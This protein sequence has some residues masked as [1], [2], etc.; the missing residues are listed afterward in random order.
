LFVLMNQ[1]I[2]KNVTTLDSRCN[3]YKSTNLVPAI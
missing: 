3:P 1:L 2:L